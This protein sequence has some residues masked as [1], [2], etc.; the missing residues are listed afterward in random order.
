MHYHLKAT[1]GIDIELSP[2]LEER[3]LRMKTRTQMHLLQR[4]HLVGLPQLYGSESANHRHEN[5]DDEDDAKSTDSFYQNSDIGSELISETKSQGLIRETG[6]HSKFALDL[7]MSGRNKLFNGNIHAA[8][9]G[10]VVNYGVG[11]FNG[12]KLSVQNETVVVSRLDGLDLMYGEYT[13]VFKCH[14]CGDVFQSLNKLQTHLSVHKTKHRFTYECCYCDESFHFKTEMQSHMRR[15]HSS[16]M[17]RLTY[18]K[19]T[20]ASFITNS[21]LSAGS[22]FS[23]RFCHKDLEN[24]ISFYKHT[25]LHMANK[26]YT[27]RICGKNFRQYTSLQIHISRNHWKTGGEAKCGASWVR[28]KLNREK[29][30]RIRLKHR[31]LENVRNITARDEPLNLMNKSKNQNASVLP[32]QNVTIVLPRSP[33][34]ADGNISDVADAGLSQHSSDNNWSESLSEDHFPDTDE[35]DVEI[36]TAPKRSLMPLKRDLSPRSRSSR[37]CT[38]IHVYENHTTSDGDLPLNFSK[39]DRNSQDNNNNSDASDD[40]QACMSPEL[41]LPVTPSNL[42]TIMPGYALNSTNHLLMVKALAAHQS[43]THHLNNTSQP[44]I[45]P[46]NHLP[47]SLA[48]MSQMMSLPVSSTP[49]MSDSRAGTSKSPSPASHSSS[50]SD[51]SPE[52]RDSKDGIRESILGYPRIP[53]GQENAGSLWS[54]NM[55]SPPDTGHTDGR[56]V[57]SLSRTHSRYANCVEISATF[58]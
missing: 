42:E 23:C 37:K 8:S 7:S 9:N 46:P 38:P 14:L 43:L 27:C 17:S 18:A 58:D 2:G 6:N 34:T 51:T 12:S 4:G 49:L 13:S 28:R 31:D 41:N 35:A 21:H 45:F 40:V 30:R 20:V 24:S 15:R 5:L 47:P 16:A 22:P 56:K 32:N 19:D 3:Y 29:T 55:Y 52:D 39:S 26:R 54:F 10:E 36:R 48:A 33:T 11:P 53:W 25:R 50:K 57:T 44:I 1:H